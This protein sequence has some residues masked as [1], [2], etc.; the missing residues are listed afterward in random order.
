[1][2]CLATGPIP[3]KPT[4]Q[5]MKINCSDSLS[6]GQ[7]D[8][9]LSHDRLPF[10]TLLQGVGNVSPIA[11]VTVLLQGSGALARTG[12]PKVL[13]LRRKRYPG[14]LEP[15]KISQSHT[16]EQILHERFIG[17]EKIQEDDN[18]CLGKKKLGAENPG[19]IQCFFGW[20]VG[21]SFSRWRFPGW[22]LVGF[23]LQSLG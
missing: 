4:D 11:S 21:Q 3:V 6:Q 13:E 9:Y 18:L 7:E 22:L 2:L 10:T 5:A 16:I 20:E 15:R 12:F 17:R 14:S 8:D 1:M 23:Q 19:F